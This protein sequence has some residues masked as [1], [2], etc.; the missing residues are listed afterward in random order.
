MQC[1]GPPAAQP[2]PR[3]GH[4]TWRCTT[5]C[6]AMVI[7][8]LLL[9]PAGA[10][11]GDD[12]LPRPL[13][14]TIGLAPLEPISPEQIPTTVRL[15]IPLFLG[16]QP[17]GEVPAVVSSKDQLLFFDGEELARLIQGHL[18]PGP[19]AAVRRQI[20]P[21][22][23]LAINDLRAVGLRVRYDVARIEASIEIPSTMQAV[24]SISLARGFQAEGAGPKGPAD[25]SAYVN[26]LG[27][28]DFISGGDGE[29]PTI[30]DFDAAANVLGVVVEGLATWRDD[31]ES[32]WQRGDT[33][34]VHD[35]PEER[36]RY[37]AGD[38]RY[39]LSGF[40]SS[41]RVGGLGVERN[42]GLQP[43][44]ASSPAGESEI[45]IDRLSRVDVLVNG[46]RVRTLDLPPGRYN[47]RDFPFVSGTNDVALRITDEVGRTEVLQFPFVFDTT[48]LAAGEHDFGY[49]AGMPS[50]PTESGR[51][52]D[53]GDILA[54]AYHAYGITDQV[55]LGANVQASRDV[56][57]VGAEGR[58]ATGLGT[59][60][61]DTAFSRLSREAEDGVPETEGTGAA[62]RLQHRYSERPALDSANRTL[63]SRLAFRSP[64]FASLGQ[65]SASN[66]VVLDLGV[67]YG[68]RIVGDL[69]GSLGVSRQ[70]GRDDHGDVSTADLNL[71]MP[72]S[73]TVM[74]HLQL[75]TRQQTRGDDDNRA[76][77][78]FSWFPGGGGHRVESSYDTTQRS[79]R[80]D[81]SYTP[82]TR[83]DSIDADLSLG[84]SESTDQLTGDIGYTGYRFDSRILQSS[85]ADR[86]GGGRNHRTTVNL[87]TALAFADGHFGISRPIS[88]S[89]VL[90][91]PH[92]ALSGQTIEINPVGDTP[93]ARTDL[94]GAPVLPDLNAY[95]ER[96]VLIDAVDLPLGYELGQ[97]VYDVRPSYR[98][99]IVV[100]VGTGAT[101]LGDGILTDAGGAPLPLELGTIASLDDES[102]APIEFFTSRKGRF[103]VEGL[104]PGR[105]QLTLANAPGNAIVFTIPAGSAGRVDL[106]QLIYVMD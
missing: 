2:S 71:S 15:D 61:L 14:P 46:Q 56:G 53:D 62:V 82:Q 105:F 45:E 89:F 102:R 95:Y 26:L 59:F 37:S 39:G 22:G 106:G 96:H 8:A 24:R 93:A 99:G 3:F 31:G 20:D 90:F 13:D 23:R 85:T 38:V 92:Q 70:F 18:L 32:R 9:A 48:V 1:P 41:R 74:A 65:T 27:A 36:T 73:D 57:L 54:S 77:L 29:E 94:L 25:V 103:R 67:L 5:W 40:Q 81:W 17:L 68:Q 98:S 72:I 50:E 87:G 63:S 88:D 64:E 11:A 47:V 97:Q 28:Q 66:P 104:A 86:D 69:Y 6:C 42:F 84:R 83:V 34:L 10:H 52:Y 35:D 7:G 4:A 30:V 101:V 58:W 100:P 51:S 75:G 80:L 76:F 19:L 55:T 33:R 44:R 79:S 12:P 78:S 60:R 91:A 43:Y 21:G 16:E 49:V